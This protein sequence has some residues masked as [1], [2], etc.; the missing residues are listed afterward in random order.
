MS[1]KPSIQ[2]RKAARKRSCEVIRPASGTSS[3]RHNVISDAMYAE[4]LA[5]CEA[6][7]QLAIRSAS[8]TA[9]LVHWEDDPAGGRRQYEPSQREVALWQRVIP[10]LTADELGFDTDHFFIP[11]VEERSRRVDS[12]T[13][14]VSKELV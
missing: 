2:A 13:V 1:A 14:Q 9:V 11:R 10:D 4:L 12:K 5:D 3:R 8:I 7:R 6:W